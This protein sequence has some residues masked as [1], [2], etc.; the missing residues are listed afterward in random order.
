M[1]NW[2]KKGYPL[3]SLCLILTLIVTY[4]VKVQETVKTAYTAMEYSVNI[5]PDEVLLEHICCSQIKKFEGCVLSPTNGF[6]GW[7]HLIKRDESFDTITKEYADSL[8]KADFNAHILYV[9][10]VWGNK[11][12]PHQIYSLALL[13]YNVG[14]G[15]FMKKGF[16]EKIDT[17]VWLSLCNYKGNPHKGLIERRKFEI[18]MY[19][20]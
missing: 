9:K 17:N 3:I 1:K 13:S 14:V 6:I 10:D 12:K 2:K 4:L 15:T 8:L 11:L 19:S 7:G 16:T 18:R 20:W 5:Q